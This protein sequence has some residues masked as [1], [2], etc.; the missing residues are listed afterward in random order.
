MICNAESAIYKS[1]R[2]VRVD[3]EESKPFVT[4]MSRLNEEIMGRYPKQ[5]QPIQYSR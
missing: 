1:V 4:E 3:V 2:A 5:K